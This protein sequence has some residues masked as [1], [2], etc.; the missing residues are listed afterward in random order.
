MARP[1]DA[2]ILEKLKGMKKKVKNIDTST[3]AVNEGIL[4]DLLSFLPVQPPFKKDVIDST[5]DIFVRVAWHCFCIDVPLETR[6]ECIDK[7][8]ELHGLDRLFQLYNTYSGDYHREQLA[9]I[10]A[11]FYDHTPLNP[12]HAPIIETLMSTVEQTSDNQKDLGRLNHAVCSI[13][14]ISTHQENKMLLVQA[15]IITPMLPLLTHSNWCISEN[16]AVV[17]QNVS[18][19]KDIEDKKR[20]ITKTKLFSTFLPYFQTFSKARSSDK[21]SP[22]PTVMKW[23][24]ASL[25]SVINN[26][27]DGVDQFFGSGLIALLVAILHVTSSATYVSARGGASSSGTPG[28]GPQPAAQQASAVSEIQKYSADIFINCSQNTKERTKQLL[29]LQILPAVVAVVRETVPRIERKKNTKSDDEM[30]V[31]IMKLFDNVVSAGSKEVKGDARNLYYEEFE[32]AD[33][34]NTLLF[35]FT[36]VS[37]APPATQ[38]I[39]LVV[40][41]NHGIIA[42]GYLMKGIKPDAAKHGPILQAIHGIFDGNGGICPPDRDFNFP[43]AAK[44]AFGKIKD[45]ENVYKEY[46]KAQ[47]QAGKR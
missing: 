2:V 24:T 46:V 35:L 34:P 5:L 16:A 33:V 19:V 41:K 14:T 28:S 3:D 6:K 40:A 17:I 13:I 20:V 18:L 47:E 1:N 25:L 27:P 45:G 29:D 4:E 23:L 37:A 9:I 38:S 11:R 36:T 8:S 21:A 31:S 22:S 7:L 44:N 26:N 32:R 15:D 39:P 12:E 42:W 30:L 43:G 10:I